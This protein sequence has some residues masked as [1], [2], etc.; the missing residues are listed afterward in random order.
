MIRRP[1]KTETKVAT[2]VADDHM[3]RDGRLLPAHTPLP[4]REAEAE[5]QVVNVIV[6]GAALTTAVVLMQN[7]R[8]TASSL[9]PPI[10]T[11]PPTMVKPAKPVQNEAV[12]PAKPVQNEELNPKRGQDLNQEHRPPLDPPPNRSL[13]ATF[14]RGLRKLVLC[15]TVPDN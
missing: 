10:T 1:T 12:K 5:P 2:H 6:V 14:F 13:F 4:T 7:A 8:K 11:L 9:L 15:Q 3:A